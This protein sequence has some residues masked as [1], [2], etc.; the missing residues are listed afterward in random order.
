M[1]DRPL[2]VVWVD[3][4]MPSAQPQVCRGVPHAGGLRRGSRAGSGR[5]RWGGGV[6]AG[7]MYWGAWDEGGRFGP[8]TASPRES[9]SRR[10]TSSGPKRKPPARHGA[11]L[12]AAADLSV[13][14]PASEEV[15]SARQCVGGGATLISPRPGTITG[16]LS[17]LPKYHRSPWPVEEAA[18]A[19]YVPLPLVF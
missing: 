2:V 5:L 15:R 3:E 14:R 13:I 6:K 12:A 18:C 17:V 1:A 10:R 19:Q 11:A 16:T 9:C 7:A 8:E 4:P